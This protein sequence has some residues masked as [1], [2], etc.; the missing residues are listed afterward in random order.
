MNRNRL[1]AAVA[2]IA[3]ATGGWWWRHR[4]ARPEPAAI[5]ATGSAATDPTHRDRPAR[6][7]DIGVS[8]RVMIDDDPQGSLRLEGQVIDADEHGVAGATVVITANPPRIAI[9]EAD[10]GFVFEGL[11]GRPYT[12]IARAAKGVAGP[13]TARLT[14]K[15]D[16]VVLRLRPA[17]KLT[18][19]VVGATGQPVDG[20]TVELRGLD[21]QRATVKGPAAVFAPVVPGGYQIA[22]WAD[23]MAHTFQRI[24]IGAGD[25]SARLT[26]VAGAPVV[27]KV[28]DD[29]GD[30]VPQAR[31]RYSGA[32][33]WSQQANDR[34]DGAVTAADGSFRF[35]ALPA[36]SFRFVA[37]HPERAPGTSALVTLDGK[38]TRDGVVIAMA[39]GAI[40][41][42]HV[43]D[44]QHHPVASARV[45]IGTAATA[46]P[47]ARTFDP[48]RQAYSDAQGA[49]EIKGL[50]RLALSA[51][52]LH[53]TGSSQTVAVDATA[54]DVADLTLTLDVTGTISGTVV[55]PEGQPIEGAQVSAG[56]TFGAGRGQIDPSQ[57]RLRGFPE[58]VTDA[59][60]KFT[61]T[62]LGPGQYRISAAPAA[63]ARGRGTSR[64]GV[65]AAT[66]DTNV[67][68]VLSPDGGVKG[69][70]ALSDGSV[71]AMFTVAVQQ[72][73][74]SFLGGDGSFSLEGLAPATYQLEL[75]GPGFQTRAVEVTI[76]S[77][78]IAD[79][80]TITVVKGRSIAGTVVADGQPVPD[81]TVYAGPTVLGNGT[82]TGA[83]LGPIGAQLAASTKSTTTDASGAFSLSGFTD[84]DLTL[85]AEQDAIGRSRALR[86]PTVMP[87]Q[88]ELT[89][90]LEKFGSLTGTLH[91]GPSPAPGV[92]VTCQSTSTPGAV[93]TVPAGPDGAYR[94]DRLGPDTYKV[95]A[96]VRTA[97]FGMRF[98]SK[99]IDVPPGQQVTLDLTVDP[100]TVSLDVTMSAAS[101]H[102]GAASAWLASGAVTARTLSE[103]L[104]KMAAAGPGASW[105]LGVANGEPAHF[106]EVTPGPY[107]TCF[108]PL[109]LEVRG[110]AAF[111]YMSRHGDTLATFCQAITV[112]PSP[113]AQTA[114]I[115]VA[116][117]PFIDDSSGSGAGSGA[118]SGR[119]AGSGH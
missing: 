22:A 26:L 76:D 106:T 15:S 89:L 30:G 113:D 72:N 8:V 91:Q 75:R 67:R 92:L 103:L 70:V 117:P 98:Y 87:G 77:S 29:R 19:T 97:R 74:Q 39:I 78:K 34:L 105:R 28:V 116:I 85:I 42:G 32:S 55:D 115:P 80:G 112:A 25:A 5:A 52:A 118:G 11:V 100:G 23:G 107:S 6:N 71:P 33:D 61:L 114:T 20:A 109:P 17:G 54:G 81:A 27:G 83:Q 110:A 64:D 88:T 65:V 35:E 10:G 51:A 1:V 108:T 2:A 73:Q 3:V 46:G 90:V 62:G 44:A 94:F 18:V 41:K 47:R 63:R 69:K 7:G 14:A 4:R 40:V 60:G 58:E 86:L 50:P 31:V 16:P 45:R 49:F 12:L 82:T 37:T 59:A 95:S 111:G 102:A 9:T 43:V 119:G 93:Y 99:Q 84:G 104:L 24:Q 36:G 68:L 56:P 66:G 13:I 38:T 48:P 96:T 57:W 101:G 21:V 53:E 79:V